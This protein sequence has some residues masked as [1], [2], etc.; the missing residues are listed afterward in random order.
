MYPHGSLKLALALSQEYEPCWQHQLFWLSPCYVPLNVPDS[1]PLA[2][3]TFSECLLLE[4]LTKFVS[5]TLLVP[6]V[7]LLYFGKCQSFSLQ[8]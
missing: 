6:S 3:G 7:L 5:D 2:V 8:I 1:Y 4:L